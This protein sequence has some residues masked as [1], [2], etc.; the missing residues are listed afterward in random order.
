[1]FDKVKEYYFETA[2][3]FNLKKE[4]RVTRLYPEERRSLILFYSREY[5]KDWSPHPNRQ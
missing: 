5:F 1:M 3:E 4:V 2:K